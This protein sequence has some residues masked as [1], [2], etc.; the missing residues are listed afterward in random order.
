MSPRGDLQGRQARQVRRPGPIYA[1]ADVERLGAANVPRALAAMAAAGIETLQIRS[2]R[3][4]D[5]ELARLASESLRALAGWPGELW[6]DDRV[7]LALLF[8][9]DGVHLGQRDFQAAVARRLLP[10]GLGVGV[11]THDERQL[12]SADAD[13]AADWVALGPIFATNGKDD[14][15]PV[16]GLERLRECRGRTRKPLIA[17]GGID[18]ATMASVFAAGADS[19]AVLSAVSGAD[20]GAASRRLVERAAEARCASS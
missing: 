15:D 9:F 3:T 14:P 17:I 11:S 13:P 4:A 8:E 16:V 18:E 12:T 2:K 5:R 20:V 7:D 1:I 19:V 6:V 10:A